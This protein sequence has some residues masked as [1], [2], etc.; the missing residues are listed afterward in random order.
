MIEKED[1]EKPITKVVSALQGTPMLLVV[2]IL[3]VLILAMVTYL[4]KA[5]VENMSA[6]RTEILKLLDNCLDE[7]RKHGGVLS[8][9]NFKLK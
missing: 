3:N 6:E 7:N 2:V 4:S 9:P 8:G 1:V 5:R